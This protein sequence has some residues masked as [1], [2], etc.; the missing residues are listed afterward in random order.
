MRRL[1]RIIYDEHR[2]NWSSAYEI[3]QWVKPEPHKKPD[4]TKRKRTESLWID[5]W[6]KQKKKK[7]NRHVIY[8]KTITAIKIRD[9]KFEQAHKMCR[10]VK[11]CAGAEPSSH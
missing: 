11:M 8:G 1:G 6:T 7:R 9:P 2:Y 5:L 4:I 3:Q 10:G